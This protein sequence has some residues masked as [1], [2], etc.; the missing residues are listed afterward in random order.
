MYEEDPCTLQLP[1][2][3]LLW[4]KFLQRA[5][6]VAT[7]IHSS[8]HSKRLSPYYSSFCFQ[9]HYDF[10]LAK[11][12]VHSSFPIF[13]NLLGTTSSSSKQ[14]PLLAFVKHPN[15]LY[16][17]LLPSLMSQHLNWTFFF[18][19][20]LGEFMHFYGWKYFLYTYNSWVLNLSQTFS[21]ASWLTI[22]WLYWQF[23]PGQSQTLYQ[24]FPPKQICTVVNV[25]TISPGRK[26]GILLS[27]A[28][29]SIHQQVQL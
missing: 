18:F 26:S 1:H 9:G 13:L 4:S 15:L 7:P 8:S 28:P 5:T 21:P 14:F 23:K 20:L 19:Y 25:I 12:N 17:S 10:H 6:I 16:P 29:K 11:C 22:E 3:L 27:I 24:S 2:L